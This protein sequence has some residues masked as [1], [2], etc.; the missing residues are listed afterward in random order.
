MKKHVSAL[1]VALGVAATPV[2]AKQVN[3]RQ[4]KPDSSRQDDSK[5]K[6]AKKRISN[7]FKRLK[8]KE[9]EKEFIRE[10]EAEIQKA[11]VSN[12]STS[13]ESLTKQAKNLEVIHK[14]TVPNRG[15][16]LTEVISPLSL[17]NSS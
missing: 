1:I 13:K 5:Y 15:I 9:A 7:T 2:S 10:T 8:L 17:K 11:L 16:D 6:Q 3:K 14:E 12:L 4:Q